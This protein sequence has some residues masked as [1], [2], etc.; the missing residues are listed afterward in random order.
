MI[1]ALHLRRLRRDPVALTAAILLLGIVLA[2]LFGPALLPG[3]AG[4]SVL[5]DRFLEPVWM[6]G[7]WA[8]PL[9][10][11][12]LGRDVLARMVG[13]ARV[14]L[15]IGAAVVLIAGSLGTFLGIV[16]GYRGGWLDTVTMRVV[17]A[18]LAFPGLVIILAIVGA[19]GP[20]VGVIII[21]LSAYAWM[22]FTRLARGITVQ[23]K[24]GGHVR[25][26]QLLGCS[27]PRVVFR[28]LLPAMGGPLLTQSML[29]LGRVML[30]EASLSYLGLGLQP[31]AASWGL[32]IAE[33]RPY[34]S[35]AWWTV[36]LPGLMLAVTVLV[37]N[38]LAGWIRVQLDPLQRQLSEARRLRRWGRAADAAIVPHSAGERRR[39]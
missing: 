20:S 28:H 14:S 39:S 16:A 19:L 9:G 4:R 23:L 33:N 18:Q 15:S 7:T 30:A 29:E 2:A 25:A 8:H 17:D 22:V 13:G 37:I 6:G 36:A 32:M 10:T 26:A 38:I 12:A 27:T 1:G 34:L 35:T 3:D 5:R 24:G 21:V 31:P 11:D